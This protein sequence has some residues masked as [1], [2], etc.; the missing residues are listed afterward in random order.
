MPAETR[1]DVDSGT[2]LI[3]AG[4]GTGGHVLPGLA[5][6][7]ELVARGHPRSSILWMGSEIGMEVD[8]VPAAG[9]E[10]VTLPGRGLN[11]R[12]L[13][14]ENLKAALGLLR[15]SLRGIGVVRR[16]RPA[17]L[18]ALGGYAS[19][20]GVVGAALTRV[21]IVVAE[22]NAV[23][24]LA[25]RLAARVA[26]VCAVSFEGTDLPRSVLTGNPL[27]ASFA[28]AIAVASD[29]SRR[30]ALRAELGV[31][32]HQALVVA[33]SGSLGSRSVNRA[34]IG[35]AERLQLRGDLVVHHVI[36]RRDWGTEHAPAPELGTDAAIDYRAVEYEQRPDRYL[37]AADLFIGR[38]G[39][40]TVAE[41]TAVGVPSVLVPLPIAPRDAQRRNAA[42]LVDAGAAVVLAD[43]E[44]D[45]ARLTA[46]VTELLGD[47]PEGRSRLTRMAEAARTLGRPDAAAAVADLV[48]EHARG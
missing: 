43:Q 17:A 47:G 20:A 34:V 5:V 3:V 4:G 16:H 46:V 35:M 9:Y 7:E 36:G 14:V 33:M 24:S 37:A 6:V 39:A 25:N 45:G 12:K 10:L 26:K 48:E 1:P 27:R 8:A 23:A 30:A 13:N 2:W 31:A 18:L 19:V 28:D 15:G 32:P 22:Q 44:C 41:L 21:P 42:P 38:A 29:P 11:A 40:T